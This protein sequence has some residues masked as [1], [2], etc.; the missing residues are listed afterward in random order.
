MFDE[1]KKNKLKKKSRAAGRR[2]G[3]GKD[4]MLPCV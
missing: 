2:E 4:E 1:K 3:E